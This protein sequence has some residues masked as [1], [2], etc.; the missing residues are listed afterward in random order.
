[1]VGHTKDFWLATLAEANY[2]GGLAGIAYAETQPTAIGEL[3]AQNYLFN[4]NFAFPQVEY[5][6]EKIK[7]ASQDIATVATATKDYKVRPGKLKHYVCNSTWIDRAIAGTG[8]V[9]P[10]SWATVFHDMQRLRFAPG[11]YVQEYKF[12]TKGG[13]FPSEEITYG[14]YNVKACTYAGARVECT[15]TGLKTHKDFTFTIGGTAIADMKEATLTIKKKFIVDDEKAATSLYHKFPYLEEFEEITLEV[16]HTDYP[17]YL[18]DLETE[19][20]TM[21]VVTI[22]GWGK[23]LTLANMKA[24]NEAIDLSIPEKGVKRYKAT[25]EMGGAVAPATA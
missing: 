6:Q 13:E 14:A 10:A 8:G 7:A 23:T 20:A 19:A 3:T 5:I 21:R 12:H 17:A 2:A 11:C 22:A 4:E 18:L 1:M 15:L 25:L 9:L 16:E 24:Q